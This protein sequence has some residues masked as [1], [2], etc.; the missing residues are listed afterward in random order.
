MAD[1]QINHVQVV[2]LAGA[3]RRG[4]IAAEDGQLLELAG[5]DAADVGHE[6]VGNSVRIVAQ[7]A[8][9]MRADGIE[10]SEQH[11]AEIGMRSHIVGQDALDH[12]LR[13][14]VG[15]GRLQGGHFFFVGMGIVGPVNGRRGGE[16]QLLAAA[17]LH[18]FQ[19]GESAVDVVAVILKRHPDAFADRFIA[20]KMDDGV[21]AVT[22][23]NALEDLRAAVDAI[24]FRSLAGD[25][26]DPINDVCAGVGEVV[27][28]Y[29]FVACIHELNNGV[30]ADVSGSAGDQYIHGYPS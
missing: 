24:E 14:S 20:R 13:P 25:L 15:A 29:Y 11:R 18:G 2:A 4:I 23:E 10:V 27:N 16:D 9:F 7:Q 30:A 6:V 5:C 28:D 22:G 3:V 8:G 1:G 19:Q 26:F 21:D 17:V 12:D